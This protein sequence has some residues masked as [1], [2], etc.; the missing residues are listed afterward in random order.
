MNSARPT[1]LTVCGFLPLRSSSLYLLT[2]KRS[3]SGQ[4]DLI[5]SGY[6]ALFSPCKL[7]PIEVSMELGGSQPSPWRFSL[8]VFSGV[9]H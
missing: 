6:V 9:F 4:I 3:K 1:R 8:L 2:S 7:L 5:N